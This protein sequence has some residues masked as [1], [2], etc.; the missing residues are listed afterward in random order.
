MG[1]QLFPF[2]LIPPFQSTNVVIHSTGNDFNFFYVYKMPFNQLVFE[3]D[4][5]KYL[6]AIRVLVEI[7]DSTGKIIQRDIRD[8]KIETDIFENTANRG[9][10]LEDFLSFKL[11]GG[12]Y[13]IGTTVTDL[14]SLKEIKAE[15]EKI[16]L[17]A[18]KPE[19]IL[20]PLLIESEENDCETEHSFKLANSG[21]S[22][23]FSPKDYH[24]I[25]PVLDTNVLDL[26]VFI[27]QEKDTLI[28]QKL[29]EAYIMPLTISKC[30]DKMVIGSGFQS[31]VTKNFILRNISKNLNEGEIKIEVN[32]ADTLNREFNFG[33]IW[34]DKPFS[35]MNPEFAI[36]MLHFIE[37]D[38]VV[39]RML[40]SDETE[41]KKILNTYWVPLDPTTGTSYNE[42]MAEFYRRVDFAAREF[43]GLGKLDGTKTDRGMIYIRFGNPES[44]ERSS[45]SLGQVTETWLYKNPERKFI[46]VDERGMGNFT[47]I[48]K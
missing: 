4:K 35:L 9:L 19:L 45:N 33:V 38:S 46:F 21:P 47:L 26:S 34:F 10:F 28:H 30:S 41:Y 40:N 22:I 27:I 23:P 37:A 14:N 25:I 5:N 43:R 29:N 16:L 31:R 15:P 24:M 20:Q 8:T 1:K 12:D 6:A 32:L 17:N 36:E 44:V 2:P 48:D 39:K 7:S 42:L 18:D 3:R 11:A 13:F